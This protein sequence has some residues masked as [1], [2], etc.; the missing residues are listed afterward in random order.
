VTL[1]AIF[2]YLALQLGI[3]L[4]VSRRIRTEEDYLVAGRRLGYTLATFSIFATW[5]GAETIVGSGGRGLREGF[6]LT[7]A[8]PFG[9][10]LCLVLM[11]LVFAV[12]LWHRRL[13]TLADLFRD[14]FSV[15]T[16]RC[17]ALVLIPSSVLWAAAQIRAFG[18]VLSTG[19]AI[20]IEAAIGI[21]A[22]FTILYTAFGGLLADA[23]TD[24]IQGACSP[25]DCWPCSWAS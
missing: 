20:E 21:A 15:T 8:E 7:A 9:Y 25:S 13:T 18:S 2:A 16:E 1:L 14:R 22:G 24:V 5:F 19:T 6:S 11:G 4:W 23:I 10:G 12:P 3:G 17:A